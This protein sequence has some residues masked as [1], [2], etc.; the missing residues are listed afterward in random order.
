LHT[1]ALK[2]GGVCYMVCKNADGLRPVQ[3]RH[4][5]EVQV[6]NRRGYAVLKSQKGK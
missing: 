5:A 1:R 3:L 2:P 4:F 6:V